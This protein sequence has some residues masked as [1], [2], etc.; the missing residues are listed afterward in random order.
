MEPIRS[1]R[2]KLTLPIRVVVAANIAA[3]S[4]RSECSLSTFL[5]MITG[6]PSTLFLEIQ[7][8]LCEN[9]LVLGSRN[10]ILG[11]ELTDQL[12]GD[13]DHR[14]NIAGCENH[15][16]ESTLACF[17]LVQARC[18]AWSKFLD[19]PHKRIRNHLRA[20]PGNVCER[21]CLAEAWPGAMTEDSCPTQDVSVVWFEAGMGQVNYARRACDGRPFGHVGQK[22]FLD[23]FLIL[24]GPLGRRREKMVDTLRAKSVLSW[25]CSAFVEELRD[26]VC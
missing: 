6:K 15:S 19:S 12:S 11:N 4:F 17:Q 24:G 25:R 10:P 21:I 7:G 9:G 18:R 22:V 14:G 2:A 13:L 1:E 23:D 20:S 8:P 16:P 5:V 26:G 3:S